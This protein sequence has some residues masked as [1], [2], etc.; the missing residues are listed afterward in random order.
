MPEKKRYPLV[1]IGAGDMIADGTRAVLFDFKHLDKVGRGAE[2]P[3]LKPTFLGNALK[4]L[5]ED[6]L[7][8]VVIIVFLQ[9]I[10]THHMQHDRFVN[11]L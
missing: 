6:F 2:R 3:L 1:K 10:P 11:D 9:H 5:F 7:I 8:A 4:G